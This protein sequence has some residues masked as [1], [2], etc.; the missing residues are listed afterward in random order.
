METMHFSETLFNFCQTARCHIAS[1]HSGNL[2]S[3]KKNH[4]LFSFGAILYTEL[5]C[6]M[7][8][9]SL[10]IECRTIETT[11]CVTQKRKKCSCPDD[12]A[13]RFLRNIG[14]CVPDH[15]A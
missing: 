11:Y 3:N 13:T 6:V 7:T 2:N 14:Y 8:P 10:V 12:G 5:A 1:E 15:I 4:T 9:C